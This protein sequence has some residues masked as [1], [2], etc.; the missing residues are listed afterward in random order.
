VVRSAPPQEECLLQ[1]KFLATPMQSSMAEMRQLHDA[2]KKKKH[3]SITVINK[4]D[5]ENYALE[6]F[7][8]KTSSKTS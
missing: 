1:D 5:H 4:H 2:I 6:T 7:R 3:E 8:L